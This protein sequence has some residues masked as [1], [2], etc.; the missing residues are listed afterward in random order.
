[1]HKS[2]RASPS[3]NISFERLMATKPLLLLARFFSTMA[4][5]QRYSDDHGTD[6]EE[7]EV[8]IKRARA[9]G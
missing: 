7:E 2:P 6:G 3:F 5:A 4:P 1:M 8:V 9:V